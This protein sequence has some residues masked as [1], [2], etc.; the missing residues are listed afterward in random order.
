MRPPLPPRPLPAVMAPLAGNPRR[1]GGI[2][3]RTKGAFAAESASEVS[4]MLDC[5]ARLYWDA[6]VCIGTI[7]RDGSIGVLRAEAWRRVVEDPHEMIDDCDLNRFVYLSRA[8]RTVPRRLRTDSTS[9]EDSSSSILY[10]IMLLSSLLSGQPTARDGPLESRFRPDLSGI[11]PVG[12]ASPTL[13][14]PIK[15][16]KELQMRGR[17]PRAEA[18]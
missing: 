2:P 12:E 9:V 14:V 3:R 6:A 4:D 15:L 16:I 18:A 11:L 7:P 8:S 13:R 1:N 17:L 10:H 5:A